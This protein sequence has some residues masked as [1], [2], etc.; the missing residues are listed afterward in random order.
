MT[1]DSPRWVG[2]WWIGF[3]ISGALAFLVALPIN[4][5]PK[6]LPGSEKY[7]LEREKEVYSKKQK[8]LEYNESSPDKSKTEAALSYKQ[9]LKSL[10]ILLL[11]PTFMFLNL[12]AACEG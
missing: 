11:N 8:K 7:K 10:K 6:S 1:P 4:G 9:M 3:L 2:A 5:F 12:A